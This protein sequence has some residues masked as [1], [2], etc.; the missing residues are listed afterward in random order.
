[1]KGVRAGSLAI[2]G[3]IDVKERSSYEKWKLTLVRRILKRQD[4]DETR[5]TPGFQT[6]DQLWQIARKLPTDYEPYGQMKRETFLDCSGNC[7]WF[8]LLAGRR[9]K[10]WG[11]CANPVSPRAGL[12]TFEHQGC[13]KYEVDKRSSYLESAKSRKAQR[14][15]EA[16][17]EELRNWRNANGL[18]RTV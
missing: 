11:V 15:F 9:G 10:D 3:G 6:H 13:L 16:K 17:E 7:R 1:M 5:L 12:L 8:H 2:K 14:Q 18:Q 4:T